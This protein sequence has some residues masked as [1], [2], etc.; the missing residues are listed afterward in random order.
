MQGGIN[1]S[2]SEYGRSEV[3]SHP[4]NPGDKNDPSLSSSEQ[5]IPTNTSAYLSGLSELAGRS[6]ASAQEAVE[7]ILRLV[8]DQLGLRSS[9]LTHISHEEGRNEVLAAHNLTG[10]SNVQEGAL[11]ELPQTF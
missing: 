11:L 3:G 4:R 8:V 5:R 9:F 1:S 10:G 7:A 2:P 6:F